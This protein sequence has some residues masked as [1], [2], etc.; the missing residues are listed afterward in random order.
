MTPFE[1]VVTF[2]VDAELL[3]A[4]E[5]FRE[6]EG[7]PFSQQIRRGLKML[8]ESKGVKVKTDR[9]RALTRKRP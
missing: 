3:A 1:Q 6:K 9:K 2:R 8:L 5:S 7:V 4:M